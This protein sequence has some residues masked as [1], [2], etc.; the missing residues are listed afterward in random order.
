VPTWM[1]STN[2]IRPR[3]VYVHHAPITYTY[4]NLPWTES[5]HVTLRTYVHIRGW[6][7]VFLTDKRRKRHSALFPKRKRR[8][9]RVNAF[10]LTK[11]LKTL[12]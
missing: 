4:T 7:H 1:N 5:R 12:N 8:F 2:A 3:R 11:S 10:S 6:F 9:F